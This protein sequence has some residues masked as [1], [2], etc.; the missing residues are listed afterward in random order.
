MK[1][2]TQIQHA[3]NAFKD[4]GMTNYDYGYSSRRPPSITIASYSS[5][6]F[7]GSIYNRIAID[8]SM[9]KI[10][11]V[12][13]N[14]KNED[15]ETIDSGLNYCLGV[16]ANI[17][18]TG[19]SFMHDLVYSMFDEG[20]VAVVPTDTTMSPKTTGSYDINTL[21]V[22]R[23]VQWF[24]KHVRI[25]LYNEETGQNEDIT[26]PKTMVA[27][28]ENPLYAVMNSE[29]S[30]LKRLVTKI[31]QLD[32]ADAINSAGKMDLIIHIPYGIKTDAQRTMA[33]DRIK[34]I[35]DQLSMGKHGIT[36]MD[37][38]EKITQLNRSIPSEL[39]ETI[40]RLTKQ[41]YNQ[42]GLTQTI[43]DGT[44]TEEQLRIYY[45]RT[46]DPIIENILAEL[47]RK[48]LTKTS[49]TQG[50]EL[51][52]YRDMFKF[53]TVEMLTSL[54]DTVRRNSIMTSNEVRK[55]FKVRP[56]SDPRADDLYNPNIADKNQNPQQTQE[57]KPG[58][59]TPPDEEKPSK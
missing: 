41:L 16:E 10:S 28:I 24:P 29:N 3:W 12:K 46:I 33:N 57:T 47:Y 4:T 59:L 48:F 1:L 56:H 27:I 37:A 40:D 54:G 39:P 45:S 49:R 43:F 6:S 44:A 55:I 38:T 34:A 11:H 20:V 22:G 52:Y 23:I 15:V 58:S 14:L 13:V 31:T 53:V 25:N 42:L 9:V 32:Q 21:R 26:M 30:T 36:Y 18:Q 7:L 50:H 8:V 19:I 35:E 17:D 2:I 5:T 51:Q